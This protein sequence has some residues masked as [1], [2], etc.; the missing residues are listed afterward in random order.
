M[1]C[2]LQAID[3]FLLDAKQSLSV[4]PQTVEEIGEVN[5]RHTELSRKKP[6][7]CVCVCV[8]VCVCGCGCEKG[9]GG[10]GGERWRRVGGKVQ[11]ST[12][13]HLPLLSVLPVLLPH[14]LLLPSSS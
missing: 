13:P 5:Q 10:G 6:E 7:V 11:W 8:W 2:H 12:L 3:V 14:T 9:E 1:L 4:R